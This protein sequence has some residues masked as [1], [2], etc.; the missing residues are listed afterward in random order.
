MIDN[1]KLKPEE[2]VDKALDVIND[3]PEKE[4][5]SISYLQRMLRIGYN[6]SSVVVDIL[7]DK[8][9]MQEP[10]IHGKRKINR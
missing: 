9:F 5:L 8:G 10:D 6:K 4:F 3:S 2:L 7:T 1:N